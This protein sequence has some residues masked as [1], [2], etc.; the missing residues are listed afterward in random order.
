MSSISCVAILASGL[1]VAGSAAAQTVVSQPAVTTIDQAIEAAINNQP[2]VQ[3]RWEAFLAA[4]DDRRVVKAGYFPT[5]SVNGELGVASREYDDRGWFD[6]EHGEISI[7]QML[8]DGFLV[9]NQ[10]RE[11]DQTRLQ[12]YYELQQEVQTKAL[13][14]IE[15]YEDVRQYR[16]T[17][18]LAQRNYAAHEG[19]LT[20]IR[21]RTESGVAAGADLQQASGRLALAQSNLLTEQANLH[22]VSARFQRIVGSAPAESLAD[23]TVASANMPAD[24]EAV[25]NS[26]LKNHPSLYAAEANVQAASAN[27]DEARSARYPRV[28]FDAR[29]GSYRNMSSFDPRFDPGESGQESFVGLNLT[30]D[31]YRGGANQAREG[32]AR[33]RVYQTQDLLQKACVDLRQTASIAWNDVN[34]LRQRLVALEAHRSS[35]ANV[36]ATYEQQFYIGRRTL[37][38]VLDAKNEAFQAERSHAAAR[39]ELNK[40][41]YRTLYAMGTLL[42]V[43][44]QTRRG[45]PAVGDFDN[46]AER[47]AM[48]N[49]GG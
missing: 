18:T 49:C 2:E 32:A 33:R 13:E 17:L 6:R 11:A 28:T 25:M 42:D 46:N 23:Y 34:N 7:T 35:S 24:F 31:L 40:A 20:L 1:A 12:R 26:A 3:A 19:V 36:A 15:A 39:H 38:D 5:I 8:F 48:I 41:Y 29:H 44:G 45:L 14:A 37:L 30:Y 47:P 9:R 10:L 4:G 16:E 27:A 22:D 21:Q 43:V